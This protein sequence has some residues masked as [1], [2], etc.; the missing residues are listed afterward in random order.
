[1]A[2][3]L[4]HREP[5]AFRLRCLVDLHLIPLLPKSRRLAWFYHG[6]DSV[7]YR[8]RQ[9]LGLRPP[10][11][12]PR[13]QITPP[14]GPVLRK[15]L[16]PLMPGPSVLPQGHSGRN[17]PFVSV[18]IP[19]FNRERYIVRAVESVLNQT[20]L[21]L[22]L[23]VVDD[24]STDG[25]VAALAPYAG[26]IRLIRQHNAGV[27][28][29]RNVGIRAAVGSWIA[30]L[31]ADDWWKPAKLE[32]QIQLLERYDVKMCFTRCETARGELWRDI[33]GVVSSVQEPGVHYVE[34]AAASVCLAPRHPYVQSLLV[35]KQLLEQAGLFDQSLPN[36]GDTEVLFK[37]SFY[38]GYLYLN[39][40]LVVIQIGQDN[41]L[42]YDQAPEATRRRLDSYLRV[43]AEM[44]WR[45]VLDD[46]AKAALSRQRLAYYSLMR[47][48]LACANGDRLLAR[49]LAR[50]AIVME[51]DT[52]TFVTA[53]LIFLFPRL[54]QA[55]CRKHLHKP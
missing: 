50:D 17:L 21:P 35:E 20:C 43:Q 42:T 33:E 54:L 13:E 34:D 11:K 37:L 15:R 45:L 12:S 29:A 48:E 2:E 16:D 30:F 32:R 5:L 55:S 10:K 18:V 26:R 47:A 23:I 49:V 7:K 3:C 9:W 38:S 46:P 52:R 44:Y 31:D 1:M 24:G 19:V 51:G 53:I 40:S 22:E 41:S 6:L 25:T 36:A 27:S 14:S 39:E 8:L 4:H 28:T